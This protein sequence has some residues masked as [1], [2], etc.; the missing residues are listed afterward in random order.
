MKQY[1]HPGCPNENHAGGFCKKYANNPLET[2]RTRGNVE[3]NDKGKQCKVGLVNFRRGI[4]Q[5]LIQLHHKT[6]S[7]INNKSIYGQKI[8]LKVVV[9]YSFQ[10]CVFDL[11]HV[12]AISTSLVVVVVITTCKDDSLLIVFCQHIL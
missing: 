3:G 12:I 5:Q 9:F 10:L 4:V 2:D 8:C 11:L 1:E 7:S 6:S